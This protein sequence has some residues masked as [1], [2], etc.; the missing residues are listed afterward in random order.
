MSGISGAPGFPGTR[1]PTGAQGAVGAHGPKGNNVSIG[2]HEVYEFNNVLPFKY[3]SHN[4]CMRS[5]QGLP[6]H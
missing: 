6:E 3:Y 5:A 2:R 1:G 4:R